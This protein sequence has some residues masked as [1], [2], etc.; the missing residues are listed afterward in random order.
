MSSNV[1]AV[2]LRDEVRWDEMSDVMQF[3][4]MSR[5]DLGLNAA[6]QSSAFHQRLQNIMQIRDSL[7]LFVYWSLTLSFILSKKES[8]Q[9]TILLIHFIIIKNC[10][11]LYNNVITLSCSMNETFIQIKWISNTMSNQSFEL[12]LIMLK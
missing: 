2:Q 5:G 7:F 1:F 12:R 4:V 9:C 6:K 8:P 10:Q 3:P 11:Y